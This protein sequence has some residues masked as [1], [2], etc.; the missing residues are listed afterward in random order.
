MVT[1]AIVCTVC[2]AL[3]GGGCFA[4]TDFEDLQTTR[5]ETFEL[6]FMEQ[7]A[8]P[9]FDILFV[10]D[11]PTYYDETLWNA[12]DEATVESGG[13]P[14]ALGGIAFDGNGPGYSSVELHIGVITSDLGAGFD[15]FT[16]CDVI[17][18][19]GVLR[20]DVLPADTYGEYGCGPLND[21]N[22]FLR[23]VDGMVENM[24]GVSEVSKA[25]QCMILAQMTR[26][27]TCPIKQPL[28]AVQRALDGHGGGANDLFLRDQGG[29][30]VVFISGEDDCSADDTSVYNPAVFG[31]YHC[32]TQGLDCVQDGNVFKDCVEPPGGV[33]MPTAEL[34]AL[35]GSVKGD[36][37]VV[38]SVMA[39]P[40]D[41]DIGV[42]ISDVPDVGMQIQPSCQGSGGALEALPAVR[43][44]LLQDQ[45]A[46]S[47]MFQEICSP[48]SGQFFEG[49]AHKL[50]A[51]STYR[52]MPKVPTDTEPG[53]P[54]M[55]AQCDIMDVVNPGEVTEQR[56][57]PYPECN[58]SGY[59][60]TCWEMMPELS[61][62][63]RYKLVL[64]RAPED[65]MESHN[66]I[67][68]ADC[69]VHM[70]DPE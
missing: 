12:M 65:D 30:A 9:E 1:R 27:T 53:R 63:A 14:D 11:R 70:E 22:N 5:R 52:C 21:G 16:G 28:R 7:G 68:E 60:V 24:T 2:V 15:G 69:L 23:V 4:L 45:F 61:C 55:Q 44:S 17:G 29:L 10:V 36:N 6:P 38:V 19:D 18:D 50:A 59:G 35:L 34:A 3:V 37:A 39:G 8:V 67:V 62:T 48:D 54:G 26:H 64:Q 13:M 51:Q 66:Y 40:Y 57:G 31:P 42:L 49:V 32:L 58:H 33:L 25:V 43:L 56:I 20:P 46:D 41:S 47:A